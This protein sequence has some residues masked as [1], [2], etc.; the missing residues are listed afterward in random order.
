[1]SMDARTGVSI[2]LLLASAGAAG[3]VTESSASSFHVRHELAIAAAPAIAW[4][5]LA[6]PGRWWPKEHTW[7][8]D[9]D[10]LSLALTAGG[11]F[12]ERWEGGSAEHARVLMVRQRELLRMDA[13]LGPLQEMGL[14]GL[15]TL[16][17]EP[18]GEG[19]EADVSFRASGD[20][21][22]Q[23]ENLAPIVDRVVAEQWGRWVAYANELS[24]PPAQR[25]P[26]DAN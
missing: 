19:T 23:L 3:E 22:H 14:S 13:P 6:T 26:P 15:L 7:S 2:A 17:L 8:G 25:P 5:A 16:T 1:M 4:N 11:C 18:A 20:A 24:K 21:S 9:A 12:C 10:K